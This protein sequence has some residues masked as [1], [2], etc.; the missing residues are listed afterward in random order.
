MSGLAAFA[1]APVAV[2]IHAAAAIGAFGLGAWQLIGVKGTVGHRRIGWTW[3]ALMI[4]VAISSL[5]I[6]QLRVIGPF[7]P[8]HLLTLLVLVQ[9][10]YGLLAARQGRVRAHRLTM[11]GLFCGAL[12]IAGALTFLPGRL[13][14][15]V[16][17]GG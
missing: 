15:A 16:L 9:L 1:A 13:M 4:V 8:I 3:A 14:H 2:Q 12:A 17:F 5:F 11:L 6:H 10:P 7:S